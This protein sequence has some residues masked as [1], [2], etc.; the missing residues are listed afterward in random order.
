MYKTT[1]F[2]KTTSKSGK[3]LKHSNSAMQPSDKVLKTILQFSSVYAVQQ[4]S[5]EQYIE[6]ILN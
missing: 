6:T 3:L 4:I 1:T 2:L 5:T